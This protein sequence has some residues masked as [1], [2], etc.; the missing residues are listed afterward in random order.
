MGPK[1][2]DL[3]SCYVNAVPSQRQAQL[4]W[5]RCVC[6]WK[7]NKQAFSHHAW[8]TRVWQVLGTSTGF[9]GWLS[10]TAFSFA[11]EWPL[12]S[13]SYE[14]HILK[15]LP[16]RRMEATSFHASSAT[17][18]WEGQ[19]RRPVTP[20]L[21]SARGQEPWNLPD[22]C[23]AKPRGVDLP[24]WRWAQP[25]ST[26]SRCRETSTALPGSCP[27]ATPCPP[28]FLAPR[29]TSIAERQGRGVC[30]RAFISSR[31]GKLDRALWDAVITSEKP[32]QIYPL[33]VETLNELVTNGNLFWF[34]PIRVHW[35]SRKTLPPKKPILSLVILPASVL[36]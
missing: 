3:A 10:I 24:G 26:S 21:L 28:S 31:M 19:R 33:G 4:V 18:A 1:D 7:G 17:S 6:S 32:F 12:R 5:R 8:T 2:E 13:Q 14:F 25:K 16:G 36:R 30:P 35:H 23:Q 29:W 27:M 20:G 34:Q 9:P 22:I 15:E 11:P